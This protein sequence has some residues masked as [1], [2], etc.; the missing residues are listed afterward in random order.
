[1]F[2][3]YKDL[4]GK[5]YEGLH[6]YRTFNLATVDIILTLVGAYIITFLFVYYKIHPSGKTLALRY[7]VVIGV[8][9]Y[10]KSKNLYTLPG[11]GAGI[12][13]I[14]FALS[15]RLVRAGNFMA[16]LCAFGTFCVE[17]ILF[18]AVL[19]LSHINV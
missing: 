13:I 16:K 2:C 18:A 11:I 8:D 9:W 7:N 10:G 6:K 17:I 1:M 12:L 19:F 15:R 5:P 4:L 3:E 14:N